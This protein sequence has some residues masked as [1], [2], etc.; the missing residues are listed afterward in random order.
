[1]EQR[2]REA[3]SITPTALVNAGRH[4]LYGHQP[5][6]IQKLQVWNESRGISRDV[7]RELELSEPTVFENLYNDHLHP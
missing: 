2:L 7:A 6:K 4:G 5:M 1:L 3:E